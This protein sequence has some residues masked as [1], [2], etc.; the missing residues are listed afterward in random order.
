MPATVGRAHYTHWLQ[1]KL[2]DN[3]ETATGRFRKVTKRRTIQEKTHTWS[4][5]FV[6]CFFS[7]L[8][9]LNRGWPCSWNCPAEAAAK[10][11]AR[12]SGPEN[13]QRRPGDQKSIKREIGFLLPLCIRVTPV[14]PDWEATVWAALVQG[15]P[16]ILAR[17]LKKGS[18]ETR[19]CKYAQTEGKWKSTFLSA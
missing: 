5:L 8:P 16:D 10:L 6:G 18:P 13:R 1:L 9:D 7:L 4:H 17:E 11:S 19:V 12:L 14:T 3:T 2:L 15:K